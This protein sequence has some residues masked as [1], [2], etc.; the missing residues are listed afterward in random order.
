MH[1]VL[2][3]LFAGA[4]LSAC[5]SPDDTGADVVVMPAGPPIVAGIAYVDIVGA[6]RAN[7]GVPAEGPVVAVW[8]CQML[9]DQQGADCAPVSFRY[10]EHRII[11]K[12]AQGRTH[13]RVFFLTL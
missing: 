5:G 8:G 11:P 3:A 7:E 10:D 2:F 13:F 6:D 12:T 4:V 9:P 1:C